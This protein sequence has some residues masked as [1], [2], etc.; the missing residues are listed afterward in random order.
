[1]LKTEVAPGIG[2]AAAASFLA[3]GLVLTY[4]VLARLFCSNGFVESFF[5]AGFLRGASDET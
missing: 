2:P 5:G 1:M 4:E 3:G